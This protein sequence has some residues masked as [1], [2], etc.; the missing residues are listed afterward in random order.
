M[1]E[2]LERNME[3]EMYWQ[4]LGCNF[5][6]ADKV[7]DE[8]MKEAKELLSQEGIMSYIENARFIGKMGRGP[9]PLVV[10]LQEAPSV[11]GLV[12]EEA[13]NDLREFPHYMSTHTNFKAIVPFLQTVSAVSRRLHSY[14]LL[15]QY[16]ELMRDMLDRTSVSVLGHHTTFPSPGLEA[17][18]DQSP[19]LLKELSL[20]GFSNW[21]DYGVQ[22]YN[23]HPGRQL[24]YFSMQSPDAHAVMQRERHGTLLVDHE[25]KLDYYLRGLWDDADYLIPY[26]LAFDE[27][28]K[29]MPYFDD[30]G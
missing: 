15:K 21:V 27:L 20:E 12:G 3:L 5:A 4:K 24:D 17:L 28:R 7:F 10:Y 14:E 25:R 19:R 1:P 16:I 8:C 18:L 26:S 29:P 11:A 13:L 22:Y 2:L 6:Q 9:E 23:N 30:T